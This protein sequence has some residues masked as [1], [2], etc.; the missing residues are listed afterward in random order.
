MEGSQKQKTLT[1]EYKIQQTFLNVRV[2]SGLRR[3][4]INMDHIQALS[5][6]M[7]YTKEY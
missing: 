4:F 6:L 3:G 5:E 7:S 1:T 2:Q